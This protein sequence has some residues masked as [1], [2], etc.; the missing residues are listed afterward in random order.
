MLASNDCDALFPPHPGST[1][2]EEQMK[3]Q[4]LDEPELPPLVIRSIGLFQAKWHSMDTRSAA[5]K[6]A[7]ITDTAAHNLIIRPCDVGVCS[8]R[9]IPPVLHE[10][11]EPRH[12]AFEGR[13]ARSLF[14]AFTESLKDGAL[15]EL[16]KRTEALHGLLETHIGLSAKKGRD[17]VYPGPFSLAES[18]H[19]CF[20]L[21]L[22]PLR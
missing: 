1:S 15:S 9:I 7:E 19:H 3:A 8:L 14:N 4:G 11:R 21:I 10:W 18:A 20:N 17:S 2:E 6:E 22:Y 16:P 12:V 5:F 13:S